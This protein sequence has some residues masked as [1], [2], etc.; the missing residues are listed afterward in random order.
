MRRLFRT[1]NGLLSAPCACTHGSVEV[2]FHWV[3]T[4]S[5]SYPFLQKRSRKCRI[6]NISFVITGATKY[7]SGMPRQANAMPSHS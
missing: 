3:V 5:V 6:V 1:V 2:V 7:L 4:G